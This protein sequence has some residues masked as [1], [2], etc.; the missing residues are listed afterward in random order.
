MCWWS[1]P[2]GLVLW[3]VLFRYLDRASTQV[4][5]VSTIG[6]YVALP[7]VT[8]LIF[9]ATGTTLN[10]VGLTGRQPSVYHIVG[11][12]LNTNQLIV[13]GSGA[14]I[15]L[16]M[17]LLI[18]YTALGLMIRA[19]VDSPTVSRLVGVDPSTVSA[20]AWALGTTMAGL[21][22]VLL[23][24]L[25]SL[26]ESSFDLLLVA[27]FAA[28][29][30]ARMVSLPLAFAGGL[31]VGLVQQVSVKYVPSTI[32]AL[33]GLVTSI[34]FLIMVAVLIVYNMRGMATE[35]AGSGLPL[36]PS[37]AGLRTP[38][39][40]RSSLNLAFWAVILLAVLPDVLSRYWLGLV[41]EG[42]IFGIIFLSFTVI[43]GE[44]GVLSLAQSSAA[45]VGAVALAQLAT[46]E[47]L[48]F[49]VA[50]GGAVVVTVLLGVVVAVISVRL[51]ELYVAL[52]TLGVGL[53][54]D[55]MIFAFP[56]FANNDAGVAV[57]PPR[58]GSLNF[59]HVRVLYFTGLLVFF[60]GA[61]LVTNLKRSTT[62]LEFAALRTYPLRAATLG[63]HGVGRRVWALAIAFGIAGLGGGL[64]AIVLNRANPLDFSTQTGIVWF[65]I[66]VTLGVRYPSGALA[67]GIL[68]VVFPQ[69]LSEHL[70]ARWGEIPTV[71]FGLGAI[72]LARDPRGRGPHQAD[73][74]LLRLSGHASLP[75]AAG[76]AR[77]TG[78]DAA[79]RGQ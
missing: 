4:R 55:N 19:S 73:R 34:P 71:L 29:V 70:A 51:G 7:A 56:R 53:L 2:L 64:L 17:Y 66:V 26:Q 31:V 46:I 76:A 25:V 23:A 18:Q 42:V 72:G 16:G 21:A 45:G 74:W 37:G 69:F 47:H 60:C 61:V 62:G 78:A 40:L 39:R 30:I 38:S 24:P 63:I 49:L 20:A 22:G 48:P 50:L 41:A 65:A 9:G 1:R 44:A 28:V 15:A 57:N 43:T 27:A 13:L 67:A 58:I 3:A 10:V 5:L 14:V 52:T 11:I 36:T 8:Q 33:D 79:A 68:S 75:T 6:L 59:G 32:T 77:S 35:P 12:A 54:F